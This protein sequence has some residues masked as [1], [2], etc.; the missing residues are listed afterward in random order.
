M[1]PS[2]HQEDS[3]DQ[4]HFL[5]DGEPSSLNQRVAHAGQLL[6]QCNARWAILLKKICNQSIT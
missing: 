1:P 2:W 5:E 6:N 4:G 3:E